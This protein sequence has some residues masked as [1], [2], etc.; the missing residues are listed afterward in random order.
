MKLFKKLPKKLFKEI[1]NHYFSEE[2][3]K[4]FSAQNN[5]NLSKISKELQD[6]TK[7]EEM[8]IAQVFTVVSVYRHRGGQHEYCEN[9]INFSQ[10]IQEFTK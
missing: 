1:C 8:L 3:S 6:L 5:M 9:V 2:T 4:K 10:D 7:I